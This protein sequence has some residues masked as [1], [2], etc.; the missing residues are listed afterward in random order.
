MKKGPAFSHTLYCQRSSNIFIQDLHN[1]NTQCYS[2]F[3]IVFV[4]LLIKKD[5]SFFIHV[6][7]KLTSFK[8]E[9]NELICYRALISVHL[10]I[11]V[12]MCCSLSL[13]C[14]VHALLNEL[15]FR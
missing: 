12:Y 11:R 9:L 2:R 4:T 1:I 10:Y 13:M 14:A 8:G 6:Y 7:V 15:N 5:L 3:E